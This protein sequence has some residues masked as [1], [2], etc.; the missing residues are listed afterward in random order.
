SLLIN[1]T[2]VSTIDAVPES[3]S[4]NTS[5]DHDWFRVSLT[6]GHSYHFA[7]QSTSA[8]LTSLA[9]DLRGSSGNTLTPIPEGAAPDF[10]YTPSTSGTYYLAVSA[11]GSS[12]ASLRGTYQVTTTDGGVAPTNT[13]DGV[14]E[15]ASTTFTL[16]PG[17]TLTGAID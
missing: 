4:A 9:I 16:S 12:P 14:P 3:G 11:G 8:A 2:I 13:V 5:F 1:G 7:A 10:Y 17:Q 6:A 15:S